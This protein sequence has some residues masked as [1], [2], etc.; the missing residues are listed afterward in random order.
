MTPASSRPLRQRLGFA[1]EY[2]V[3]RVALALLG[4]LPLNRQIAIAGRLGATLVPNV[5]SL[6]KRMSRNLDLALPGTPPERQREIMHELGDNFGRLLME[7]ALLAEL[8]KDHDRVTL[9]GPGLEAIRASQAEGRGALLVSAHFG[10]WES[11][12]MG[13]KLAGIECGMIYRAFNNPKFDELV[14]GRMVAAGAPV[15][16]KGRSGMRAFV[17]HLAKG[18]VALILVDQKQTGAPRLPFMDIPAE[19][20]PAAAQLAMRYRIPMVPAFGRRLEDGVSFDVTLEEPIT[21]G[22]AT[23]RMITMNARISDWIRAWPGQWL[24]LHRRWR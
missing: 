12:R 3:L 4:W 16:V 9:H 19:T 22:D 5:A 8:V 2:A 20:V 23:E 21:E 24:W 7:Y 10:N 14:R 6:R 13:L 11:I 1:A 17:E 15:V 18:G